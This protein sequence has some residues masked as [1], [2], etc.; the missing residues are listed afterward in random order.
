L[1]SL[2]L[3]IHEKTKH[4]SDRKDCG[5]ESASEKWSKTTEKIAHDVGAPASRRLFL[6]AEADAGETV[7]LRSPKSPALL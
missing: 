5:G 1:E 6:Y 2:S 3:H 4:K 7:R